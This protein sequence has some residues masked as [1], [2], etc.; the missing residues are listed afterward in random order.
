MSWIETTFGFSVEVDDVTPE[1]FGT[2][3]RLA[4]WIRGGLARSKP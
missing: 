3:R 2:I 4:E 1:D